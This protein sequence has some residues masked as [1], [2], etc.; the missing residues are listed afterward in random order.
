MLNYGDPKSWELYA[1]EV[2]GAIFKLSSLGI[3]LTATTAKT[4]NFMTT[5]GI[6]VYKYDPSTDSIIGSDPITKITDDGTITNRL[7]STGD[8]IERNLVHTMIKDSSNNDIYVEY[9]KSS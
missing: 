5:D 3:E 4:K 2:Y 7:E 6:L 1:S 9:I 8:I